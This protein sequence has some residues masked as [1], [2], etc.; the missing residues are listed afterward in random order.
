MCLLSGQYV[1]LY[2]E[3]DGPFW[4]SK[5]TYIVRPLHPSSYG[6]SRASGLACWMMITKGGETPLVYIGVKQG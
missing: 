2:V 1:L 6:F 4:F 5:E 3:L